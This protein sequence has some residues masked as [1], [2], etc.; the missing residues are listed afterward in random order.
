MPNYV[1]ITYD[2]QFTETDTAVKH[3]PLC[4]DTRQYVGWLDQLRNH[5]FR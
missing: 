4:G 5:E 1:C 2:A 3:S